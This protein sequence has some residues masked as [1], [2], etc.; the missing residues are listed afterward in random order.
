MTKICYVWL[1]Q[2]PWKMTYEKVASSKKH[3]QFK[4]R[5][6]NHI[7]FNFFK[8]KWPNRYL[9][10]RPKR[11][12]NPTLWDRSCLCSPYKGVPPGNCVYLPRSQRGYS[13]ACSVWSFFVTMSFF[14][15]QL[16]L[17]PSSKSCDSTF[18][19]FGVELSTFPGWQKSL[20]LVS[21]MPSTVLFPSCKIS[22][23]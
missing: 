11:L 23:V 22:T 3:T 13:C 17:L 14:S 1:V 10:L 4:T 9:I 12:K 21:G 15:F 20:L 6:I 2:L 16:L 19:S 18:P 5:G 8:T 7:V